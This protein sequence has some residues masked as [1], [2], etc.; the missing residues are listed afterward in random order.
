MLSAKN[1]GGGKSLA[2]GA[3]VKVLNSVRSTTLFL[4]K[5]NPSRC[6][7]TRINWF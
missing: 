4:H 3:S 6:I 2:I 7:L 5:T 1:D